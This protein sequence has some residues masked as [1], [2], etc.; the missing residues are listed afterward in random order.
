MDE[1]IFLGE[2]WSFPP[3]FDDGR[4]GIEMVGDELDIR[5]SLMILL[6]TIPGE[7]VMRPKYG[8]DLHSMVFTQMTTTNET[9]IKDLIYTAIL[10]YEPRITVEE[11]TVD[12]SQYLEGLLQV[13][14]EYTIRKI[15]IRTNIVYPFYIIEG[16][17]VPDM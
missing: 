6:A 3:S 2:G 14:I 5:Q 17:N 15:N 16:T 11:I 12:S 1:R 9:I 13:N 7:R 8:C 4:H 10:E